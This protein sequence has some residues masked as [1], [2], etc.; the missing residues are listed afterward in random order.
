M[1]HPPRIGGGRDLGAGLERRDQHVE[2]RREE[3]DHEQYQEDVRPA[4][5]PAAVAA[6]AARLAR[7]A[8]A[9][10]RCGVDAERRHATSLPRRWMSRRMNTAAIARIGIMNS[11]TAAP[12]GMSL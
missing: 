12:S 10:A 5:R 7:A 1:E 4:Q 3:E 8:R 9:L 2:R 11:D 6:H